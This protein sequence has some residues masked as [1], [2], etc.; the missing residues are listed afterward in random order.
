MTID[1]VIEHWTPEQLMA[2]LKV[3]NRD[4]SVS[5]NFESFLTG[6]QHFGLDGM[7]GIWWKGMFLG[8]EKDGYTHS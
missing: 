3:Y 7:V 2:A 1:Q 4:K 5:N 8:I 6:C